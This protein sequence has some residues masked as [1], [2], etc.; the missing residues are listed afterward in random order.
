MHGSKKLKEAY[1]ENH[2]IMMRNQRTFGQM[3][4]DTPPTRMDMW[5]GRGQGGALNNL[6]HVGGKRGCLAL[7]T[8]QACMH[9]NYLLSTTYYLLQGEHRHLRLASYYKLSIH[10]LLVTGYSLTA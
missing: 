9:A 6:L 10:L 8:E 4:Q 5:C 1:A 7:T 3:L 2:F